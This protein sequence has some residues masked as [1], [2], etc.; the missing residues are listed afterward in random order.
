MGFGLKLILAAAASKIAFHQGMRQ[1]HTRPLTCM[2]VDAACQDETK[3]T[4]IRKIAR[5]VAEKVGS[6]AFPMLK[7][8]LNRTSRFNFPKSAKIVISRATFKLG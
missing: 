6:L 8:S 7:K 2:S 5:A 3:D 4:S 1:G